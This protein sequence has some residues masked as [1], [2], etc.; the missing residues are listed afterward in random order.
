MT[1]YTILPIDPARALVEFET[2]DPEVTFGI[3]ED[4]ALGEVDVFEDG[5]YAFSCEPMV[6]ADWRIYRRHTRH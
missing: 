6:G 2:P 1:L 4:K 3:I 5:K